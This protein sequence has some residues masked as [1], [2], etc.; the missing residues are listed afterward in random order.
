MDI[1]PGTRHTSTTDNITFRVS[2]V[3]LYSRRFWWW[4]E[5]GVWFEWIERWRLKSQARLHNRKTPERINT[6]KWCV[7][8][9]IHRNV[10]VYVN[11]SE[12]R[13]DRFYRISVRNSIQNTKS[14]HN[15]HTN[16]SLDKFFR[17]CWRW[18]C[19]RVHVLF[20]VPGPWKMFGLAVVLWHYNSHYSC[21]I[22]STIYTSCCHYSLCVHMSIKY[23]SRGPNITIII[24]PRLFPFRFH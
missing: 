10:F 6:R 9:Y 24:L 2:Q 16:C 11:Y 3:F 21:N 12:G 7:C 13:N 15:P 1:I 23:E 22:S 5:G 18:W 14:I 20:Y 19:K 17:C 4:E 8:C